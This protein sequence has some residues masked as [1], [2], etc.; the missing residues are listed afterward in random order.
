MR[1]VEP[2][3]HQVGN[4]QI[5]EYEETNATFGGQPYPRFTLFIKGVNYYYVFNQTFPF[6]G[7][8]VMR[9]IELMRRFATLLQE[10]DS[11]GVIEKVAESE[12]EV[13]FTECIYLKNL[14]LKIECELVN[15]PIYVRHDTMV[16]VNIHLELGI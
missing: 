3:L 6:K 1:V 14:G 10:K 9:D 13:S 4:L 11:L 8:E 5:A 15:K 16:N 2:I 7:L 12:G